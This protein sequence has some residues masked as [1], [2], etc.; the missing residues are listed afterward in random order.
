MSKRTRIVLGIVALILGCFSFAVLM[1]SIEPI[2]MNQIQA[3][4][5]TT[6]WVTPEVE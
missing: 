4:I 2:E 6:L 5:S 1:S 3:T